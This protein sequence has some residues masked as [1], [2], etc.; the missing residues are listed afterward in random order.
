MSGRADR[1]IAKIL[2]DANDGASVMSGAYD[3]G[4]RFDRS[5]ALWT[6][7]DQSVDQD[8]IPAL[9]LMSARVRDVVRNDAYIASGIRIHRDSIVGSRYRLNAKPN[10]RVLGL[11]D[12]WAREFAEEVEPLFEAWAESFNHWPDVARRNTFTELIRLAVGVYVTAGE[13]LATSE[14]RSTEAD[15]QM[16]TAIQPIDPNRLSNP[17]DLQFPPENT[18]AGV[19]MNATGKPIGYYIRRR[20]LTS[21]GLGDIGMYRW[22]YIRANVGGARFGDPLSLRPQVIHIVEQ[23]RPGQTRGVSQLVSAL[24]EIRM[25]KRFRDVTLQNAAVNASFAAT[26]ESELPDTTAFETIGA[27]NVAQTS[28][29]AAQTMMQGIANYTQ[30]SKNLQIDG[31]KI[32]HLFPGTKL[33]LQP[34][35]EPGG[36]GQDFEASFLRYLAANLGMSYEE[37]SR[38]YRQSSYSS[39]RAALNQT[40]RTMRARKQFVADRFATTIYRL[41][42]EEAYNAGMIRTMTGAGVPS[43][44]AQPFAMEAF[45]RAEWLG[46]GVTSIDPLKE[47]QASIMRVRAGLSTREEEIS[48]GGGDYRLVF[49]QLAREQA[50]AEELGLSF[51]AEDAGMGE[52][53]TEN[54]DGVGDEMPEQDENQQENTPDG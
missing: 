36:V 22:S 38:D 42:L 31:V 50:E 21:L 2:G 16:Y 47:T 41:W 32:P 10:Y 17:M 5:L 20:D 51:D 30:A 11:D 23:G 46:A 37:L 52:L 12:V 40:A 54:R 48:R 18:R 19:R 3:A 43:F 9:E 13:F 33:N 26:I 34:A 1:E 28:I 4:D 24:K 7:P 6:P 53:T 8:I 29:D 39:A 27:G 45:C 25:L 14:W 44:Y 15:R 49:E 35:G